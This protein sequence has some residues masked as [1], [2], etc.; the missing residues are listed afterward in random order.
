MKGTFVSLFEGY[1]SKL[2]IGMV[3]LYDWVTNLEYKDAVQ[4]IRYISDKKK[5]KELKALLPCI[6]PS[7]IFSYCNDECLDQHSGFICVDIDGGDINP[8][9][10][11][12]ESIKLTLGS[13]PFIAYCGLSVSGEGVFCFIPIKYPHKHKEHY[14]ALE[15]FFQKLKITIDSS[16]KNVSRL[17]GVSYDPSPI[18][19]LDAKAFCKTIEKSVRPQQFFYNEKRSQ[20]YGDHEFQLVP[21]HMEILIKFVDDNKIDIT[22]DRKQWFSIGCALA[23]EYGEDGRAIFHEFSRHYRN[24][25]YH[26]TREETDMMYDNCIKAYSS[27]NFSIATFYYY[28]KENGVI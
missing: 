2:P 1:R 11:D 15:E 12:W 20:T 6:T 21:Y 4:Q 22:G 8:K 16:C 3:T 26:Y 18:I 13:L 23:S 27:Y 19:N 7:G 9:L 24:A 5:Q 14:F 28:C 25:R 17:R 10:S